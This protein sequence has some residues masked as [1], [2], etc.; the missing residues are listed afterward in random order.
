MP[1]PL[2]RETRE[3]IAED[4]RAGLGCNAIARKHHVSPSTVSNIARARELSFDNDW[5]TMS[6]ASNRSYHAAAAREERKAGL[7]ADLLAT[8]STRARD[9]RETKAHRRIGYALYDLNRHHDRQYR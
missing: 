5:M 1:A 8:Q 4:I 2:A 3:A 6:A 7:I 9:D